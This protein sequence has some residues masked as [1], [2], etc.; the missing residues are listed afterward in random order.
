MAERRLHGRLLQALVRPLPH[1]TRADCDAAAAARAA[2][3]GAADAA[4]AA[5]AARTPPY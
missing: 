4:D 3:E 1:E 5:A 2:E